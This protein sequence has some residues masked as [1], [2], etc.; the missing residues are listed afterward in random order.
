MTPNANGGF[1]VSGSNTYAY[2][3]VYEVRVLI[4]HL[5]DGQTL[6]LNATV[7]VTSGSGVTVLGAEWTTEKLTRNKS[8]EVLD[9]TFSGAL[10]ESAADDIT[11]YILDAATKSEKHGGRFTKPIRLSTASY[12]PITNVVTLTPRRKVPRGEMRL[13]V[14][15]SLVLDVEGREID[16]NEDGQLGGNDVVILNYRGVI[17]AAHTSARKK[18][19]LLSLYY[20]QLF[21][22]RH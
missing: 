16:G 15:A 18:A 11:A 2:P 17:S 19:H 1:G 9:V 20:D 4:T 21:R 6:A 8:I 3:G 13:T 10:D 14:N 22:D 12:N 5:S 7:T